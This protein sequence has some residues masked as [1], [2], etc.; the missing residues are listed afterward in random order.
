VAVFMDGRIVQVGAPREIFQRPAQVSVAGFIGTPPMN[1]LPA[2]GHGAQAAVDGAGA[3]PVAMA[4]E[5]A[6]EVTL[7][8][9]PADL[10]L[11]EHG[12]SAR[13]EL[14]EEL[15]DSR[16]VNAAVGAHAVK[17]KTDAVLGIRE[18]DD[19][20]LAFAPAAAHLFDRTDGTRLN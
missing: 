11:A 14:I 7:G 17:F 16:I 1:L 8:V 13:I 2:T 12:L 15:G 4:S 19:V 18:G 6:R 9:R 3:L 10:R 5:G 20:K